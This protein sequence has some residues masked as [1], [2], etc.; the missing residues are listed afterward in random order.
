[1][2]KTKT[3]EQLK[4]EF[5]KA[6]EEYQ[7]AIAA[8]DPARLVAALKKYRSTFDAFNKAKKRD[9]LAREKKSKKLA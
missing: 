2:S 7:F 9:F 8:G 6:N 5:L 4:E 3:I 1:M